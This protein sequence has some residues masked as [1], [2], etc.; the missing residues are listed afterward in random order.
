[1]VALL[2]GEALRAFKLEASSGRLLDMGGALDDRGRLRSV[3][4]GPD[5]NLYVGT[6][7]GAGSDR[8]L[9]LTPG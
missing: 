9:R 4:Q 1:M 2:K 6:D 8:I 7:N 3:T 5:G